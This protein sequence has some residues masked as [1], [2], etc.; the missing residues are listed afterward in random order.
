MT[1]LVN[2][3]V[4]LIHSSMNDVQSKKPA[5]VPLTDIHDG[6]I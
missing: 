3:A 5:S 1:R 6:K 2:A 4:K